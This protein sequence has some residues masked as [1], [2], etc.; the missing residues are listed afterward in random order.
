MQKIKKIVRLSFEG[1]G[2]KIFFLTPNIS[3]NFGVRDPK[4]LVPLEI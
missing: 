4:F 1:G 3:A 2:G